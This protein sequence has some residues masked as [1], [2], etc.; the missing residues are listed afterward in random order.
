MPKNID[1]ERLKELSLT[2]LEV[3]LDELKTKLKKGSEARDTILLLIGQYEDLAHPSKLF[4]LAK[5][6]IELEGKDGKSEKLQYDLLSFYTTRKSRIRHALFEIISGITSDDLELE[7]V[8]ELYFEFSNF[9]SYTILLS[10]KF[11]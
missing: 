11:F 7:L 8:C 6:E 2:N 9:N 4:E 10:N 3:V 5:F 1:K